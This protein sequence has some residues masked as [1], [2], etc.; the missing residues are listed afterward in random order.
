VNRSSKLGATPRVDVDRL[1]RVAS[2]ADLAVVGALARAEGITVNRELR[3]S[4]L[5]D[6]SGSRVAIDRLTRLPEVKSIR[7]S[8]SYELPPMDDHIPQ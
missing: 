3:R 7:E 5:L 6:V 1:I 4:K 2:D 8:T